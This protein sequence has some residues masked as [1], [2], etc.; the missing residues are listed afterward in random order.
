VN[1]FLAA[2]FHSIIHLHDS[3]L[4]TAPVAVVGSG[5]D[6]NDAPIVLPLIALHHKLVR[7]SNKV[8][9]VNVRELFRNVLP[10]RVACTPRRDSPTAP[11]NNDCFPKPLAEWAKKR[12]LQNDIDMTS[13]NVPVIR[14]GPNQVAHGSLMRNLLHSIQ[15][16]C[17]IKCI[18]RRR[19]PSM[20]TEY[21]VCYYRRHGQV[22]KGIGKELPNIGI[23]VLPQA[24]VIET[25]TV[26]KIQWVCEPISST[27]SCAHKQHIYVK[28]TLV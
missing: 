27:E 21:A 5:K 1:D 20:E 13:P 15:I 25:I 12:K 14:I 26:Q 19:Q 11:W 2:L 6:C 18:D 17:M 16:T 10:K 8:K 22:I 24:F 28:L 23:S 7:A 9:A 3:G 4:I